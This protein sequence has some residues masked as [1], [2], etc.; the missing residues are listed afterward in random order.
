M[1]MVTVGP[2]NFPI[3]VSIKQPVQGDHL[4]NTTMTALNVSSADDPAYPELDS[5]ATCRGI[6]DEE[7]AAYYRKEAAHQR[8]RLL[9][10]LPMLPAEHLA[11]TSCELQKESR[12]C[13]PLLRVYLQKSW[14]DNPVRQ[15]IRNNNDVEGWHRRLKQQGR[16]DKLPFYV[17]V[18]S[19]KEEADL[20][21]LHAKYVKNE[22]LK[23]FQRRAYASVQ[24]KIF[25]SWYEYVMQEGRT[26]SLLRACARLYAPTHDMVLKSHKYGNG[27]DGYANVCAEK[28]ADFRSQ[29]FRIAVLID[30]VNCAQ[31]RL[32]EAHIRKILVLRDT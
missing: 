28:F 29:S 1:A 2:K 12:E 6:A 19:P 23:K 30:I 26:A 9:L 18:P 32:I 14:I 10:G 24:R 22:K 16:H 3:D 25:A 13:A 31:H 17:L 8:M 21:S 4:D 5:W 20:V 11:Q 15:P 27:H 7:R